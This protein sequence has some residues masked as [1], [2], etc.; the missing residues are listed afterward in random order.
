MR[1][2]NWSS[3]PPAVEQYRIEYLVE[4][5]RALAE[6][7]GHK[8]FVLVGH[9]WGGVV[10]WA[11]ALAHPRVL[12]KL[13]ILNAPHLVVFARELADNPAQQVAYQDIRS[14][15]AGSGGDVAGQQLSSAS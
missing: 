7:L 14:Y 5:V 9:D 10:A 11:F 3:K 2:Y 4:D 13:V 6:H 1:G 12:E 15:R 8:Q